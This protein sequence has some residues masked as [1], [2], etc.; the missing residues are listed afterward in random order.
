M[1]KNELEKKVNK[2]AQRILKGDKT[3]SVL[4][5]VKFI[6]KH[7]KKENTDE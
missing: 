5:I 2:M 4:D 7:K 1:E 6:K 3:I